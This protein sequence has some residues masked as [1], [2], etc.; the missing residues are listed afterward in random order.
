MMVIQM[1]EKFFQIGL[2]EQD[3]EML[4]KLLDQEDKKNIF[5]PNGL[6]FLSVYLGAIGTRGCWRHSLI[7]T[8][9]ARTD[10]ASINLNTATNICPKCS[11]KKYNE[12]LKDSSYHVLNK[13]S[14]EVNDRRK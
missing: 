4:I 13:Y 9:F 8:T 12:L 10:G 2:K 1:D 7:K 5:F 14:L 3:I 11:R 6:K